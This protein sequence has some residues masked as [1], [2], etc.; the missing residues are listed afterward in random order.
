MEPVE[1]RMTDKTTMIL[2]SNYNAIKQHVTRF[3]DFIPSNEFLDAMSANLVAVFKIKPKAP[4]VET[5]IRNA[6]ANA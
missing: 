3:I 1:Y 2:V 6:F 4:F 5:V